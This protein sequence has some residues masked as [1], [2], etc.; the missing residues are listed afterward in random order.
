MK[1]RIS[2]NKLEAVKTFLK[3]AD[4]SDKDINALM[5]CRNSVFVDCVTLKVRSTK[6]KFEIP[7]S[8]L[9]IDKDAIE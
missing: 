1:I 5:E 8:F 4:Y 7:F 6:T 2:K 3:N 9:F